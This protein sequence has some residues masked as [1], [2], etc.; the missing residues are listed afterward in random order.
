MP[1]V[2]ADEE[3]QQPRGHPRPTIA[4]CAALVQARWG[5][6]DRPAYLLAKEYVAAVQRAGALAL[7]VPPDESV[8]TTQTRCST[9]WMG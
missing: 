2:A 1:P 6:W 9:W 7:I 8:S 5:S 3:R 4:I